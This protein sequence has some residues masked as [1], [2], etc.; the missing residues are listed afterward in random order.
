[1]AG[2]APAAL[3]TMRDDVDR[4]G[5]SKKPSKRSGMIRLDFD[6]RQKTS[7]SQSRCVDSARSSCVDSNVNI[8][9]GGREGPAQNPVA[10]TSSAASASSG[11]DMMQQMQQFMTMMMAMTNQTKPKKRS[12]H[13]V[14]DSD[15]ESDDSQDEQDEDADNDNVLH[16]NDQDVISDPMDKLGE[17]ALLFNTVDMLI[18]DCYDHDIWLEKCVK[19][20]VNHLCLN[21]N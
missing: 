16:A 18:S 7:E 14:S 1:M 21:N 11:G 10:S 13:E 15:D 8:Q 9:D 12:F 3:P 17:S 6:G 19:I 2:K 5:G 20:S 4:S